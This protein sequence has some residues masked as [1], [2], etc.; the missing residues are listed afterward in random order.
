MTCADW[1]YA[2]HQN[3]AESEK[4]KEREKERERKRERERKAFRLKKNHITA[5]SEEIN[6]RDLLIR[7]V[8]V[9]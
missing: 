5:M 9:V 1:K 6:S 4:I 2:R 3:E 7:L 8:L